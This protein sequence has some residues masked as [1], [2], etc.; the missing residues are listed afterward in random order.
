MGLR[1]SLGAALIEA[2]VGEFVAAD[3]G[4]GHM[5]MEG[6]TLFMTER[7]LAVVLLLSLIVILLDLAIRFV[8]KRLLKWRPNISR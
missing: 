7:V 6:L 4:L 2:I 8:G 3:T 5:I 1:A